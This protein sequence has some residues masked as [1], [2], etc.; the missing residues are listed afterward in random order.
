VS[1]RRAHCFPSDEAWRHLWDCVQ[2]GHF[3]ALRELLSGAWD[4][5]L[6]DA[7]RRALAGRPGDRRSRRAWST[8]IWPCS[9]SDACRCFSLSQ[10]LA[11]PERYR[12]ALVIARARLTG[13][14]VC[15]TR[16]GS[17]VTPTDV[18]G[19]HRLGH[20][21]PRPPFG[22]RSL[23]VRPRFYN[24]DVA[25]GQKVLALLDGDP[26]IDAGEAGGVVLARFDGLRGQRRLARGLGA[27]PLQPQR[28]P[29]LLNLD[30][31]LADFFRD[32]GVGVRAW[33]PLPRRT[34]LSR[35]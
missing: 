1:K 31:S 18:A 30:V 6:S 34:P 3:T 26:F 33:P 11:W 5:E 35:S 7:S 20:S 23:R 14:R 15:C 19:G 22:S 8:K 13:R 21:G 4:H 10:A 28:H 24:L 25:T 29:L 32:Q 16:P 12:G 2:Q 17:S 27:G 9:I